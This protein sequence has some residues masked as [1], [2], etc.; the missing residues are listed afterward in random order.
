MIVKADVI[1]IPEVSFLHCFL[2]LF[3]PCWLN[4]GFLH[5]HHPP[6]QCLLGKVH[7]PSSLS[8]SKHTNHLHLLPRFLQDKAAKR[9]SLSVHCTHCSLLRQCQHIINIFFYLINL[10]FAT[11]FDTSIA[12]F[13]ITSLKIMV[14]PTG[15]AHNCYTSHLIPNLPLLLSLSLFSLQ[16]WIH[17]SWKKL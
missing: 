13:L 8:K 3:Q 5:V 10:R 7:L 9:E 17:A 12:I 16:T 15:Q 4:K 1:T 2:S 14:F 6:L 11:L